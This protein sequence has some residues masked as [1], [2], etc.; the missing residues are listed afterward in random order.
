MFLT[1]SVVTTGFV[2]IDSSGD[3]AGVPAM[4]RGCDRFRVRVCPQ[5]SQA[6]IWLLAEEGSSPL[7]GITL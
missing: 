1:I 2:M 4:V 6:C 7:K 3:W 5:I